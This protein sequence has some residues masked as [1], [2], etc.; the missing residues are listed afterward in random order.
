M[1][2]RR[3]FSSK[4]RQDIFLTAGG[5][6]QQCGDELSEDWEVDHVQAY[7]GGG[8]TDVSNARA[9]CKKCNRKKG[10][11]SEMPLR[12][13]QERS[14]DKY[15][16]QAGPDWLLVATPGAGKT[17]FAGEILRNH[18]RGRVVTGAVIVVPT[19]ALKVQ[20]AS[21]LHVLGLDI[22]PWWDNATGV[23]PQDMD[24]LAVT[25]A[26][27]ASNPAIFRRHVSARRTFVVLDE[28]H[29]CGDSLS[30]GEAIRFAFELSERRLALSGT[31]F[32][33]DN[34]A[35]PFVR[36]VDGQGQPDDSYS[37]GEA[38]ADGIVR[39]VYFPK[40]GGT[41][42]WSRGEG[43]SEMASF[44]DE[45]PEYKVADRLRTAV[46]TEGWLMDTLSDAHDKLTTLRQFDPD[47]GGIVFAID[48]VHARKTI[49]PIMRQVTGSDPLVVTTYDRDADQLIKGFA[50][51]S[52]PWIVAIRMVSE[53]I[54]I[55][56]LRVGVFATTT[57]TALFFR[58][59]VG[60]LVRMEEDAPDAHFYIPDDPRLREEAALIKEEREHILE[61]EI[62]KLQ[63]ELSVSG[64]EP[65]TFV[66][67]GSSAEDRGVIFD[68]DAYDESTLSHVNRVKLLDPATAEL[69]TAL[70]AK[71]WKNAQR[72]ANPPRSSLPAKQ[73]E[74][75]AFER[76]KRLREAVDKKA[77]SLAYTLGIEFKDFNG[78]LNKAA[79]CKRRPEATVEQLE[80][81]LG[82]LQK[83]ARDGEVPVW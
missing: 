68:G 77:K 61:V 72:F 47:A 63:D 57:T 26:Q 50:K 58:Q 41:T 48:D 23:W 62:E 40:K 51:G 29:H 17:R 30:W 4:E 46:T 55:P 43:E 33:S 59:A 10:A 28:I 3:Q 73:L 79:G 24:A 27:V 20:W 75:P 53:G 83:W 80:E 82:L 15:T 66:A 38:L 74:P 18:F 32:R 44:D 69:E 39:S 21:D 5:K 49:A 34:N 11:A 9:T 2:E 45:L 36:Y 22:D 64:R 65:S 16:G 37:Y 54:D 71:F 14:L 19:E 8:A 13:W 81:M 42:E 12:R 31:P 35:I 56:R 70:L 60:R 25:Y 52:T 1:S 67:L 78:R 76:K 7:S 6:C